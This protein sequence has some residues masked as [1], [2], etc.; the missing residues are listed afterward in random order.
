MS[1]SSNQP[2]RSVDPGD[3]PEGPDKE[4]MPPSVVIEEEREPAD[5]RVG[6]SKGQ[7]PSLLPPVNNPQVDKPRFRSRVTRNKAG[8]PLRQKGVRLPDTEEL[9]DMEKWCEIHDRDFQEIVWQALQEKFALIVASEQRYSG[10]ANQL[11]TRDVVAS[12]SA[13]VVNQLTTS[14][15][16]LPLLAN[17]LTTLARAEDQDLSLT[18]ESEEKIDDQE[19]EGGIE[20]GV[21]PLLRSSDL[22]TPPA[23]SGYPV[24]QVPLSPKE[25]EVLALADPK[26][27]EVLL[28]YRAYS[29]NRIQDR[30]HLA[31]HQGND[32]NPGIVNIPIP[33]HLIQLAIMESLLIAK[34]RARLLSYCL[35]RIHH[36]FETVQETGASL[37]EVNE[38]FLRT[39][40]VRMEKKKNPDMSHEEYMDKIRKALRRRQLNLPGVGGELEK[41]KASNG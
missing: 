10:V 18:L 8:M 16:E 9:R 39:F 22:S 2:R 40:A 17:Q 20:E 36:Y 12:Q 19:K 14:E 25:A 27:V 21:K 37:K 4:T 29:N 35:G 13:S 26:E 5:A 3:L 34:P 31:Y 7:A 6:D 28:F 1:G 24:N 33:M 32:E 23:V 15:P 41:L 38:Q 30:D 11:T